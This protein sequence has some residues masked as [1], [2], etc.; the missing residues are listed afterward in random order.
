MIDTVL[1]APFVHDLI[2]SSQQPYK[3]DNRP[4]PMTGKETDC[5]TEGKLLVQ[6]HPGS[7]QQIPHVEKNS[8][9]V[10]QDLKL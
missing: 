4:T 7:K 1:S 5:S 10:Y 8:N 9:Y 3:V 2:Y 6:G